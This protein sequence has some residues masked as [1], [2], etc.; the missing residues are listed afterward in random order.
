MKRVI[1]ALLVSAM[2]LAISQSSA[3][4]GSGLH[5]FH[6]MQFRLGADTYA[7]LRKAPEKAVGRT[8]PRE[9]CCLRIT[10]RNAT[11]TTPR[12]AG[13]GPAYAFRMFRTRL[14]ERY[15]GC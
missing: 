14:L 12:A 15:S 10:A 1:V 9:N 7:E 13:K 3:N 2:L 5:G 4:S 8:N 11:V 6:S